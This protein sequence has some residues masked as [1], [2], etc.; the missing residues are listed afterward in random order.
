LEFVQFTTALA[1][2]TIKE[3]I[4]TRL[5]EHATI[6]ETGE[7]TGSAVILTVVVDEQVARPVA[8]TV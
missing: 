4:F 3:G 2:E 7:R 6:F 1:G 8:V 5:P